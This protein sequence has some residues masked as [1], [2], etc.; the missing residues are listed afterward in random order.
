MMDSK[1]KPDVSQ[2]PPGINNQRLPKATFIE[3]RADEL[4]AAF[5]VRLEIE[6]RKLVEKG[7]EEGT[8]FIDQEIRHEALI[9]T[10]KAIGNNVAIIENDSQVMASMATFVSQRYN[11]LLDVR[12]P[13]SRMSRYLLEHWDDVKELFPEHEREE[14]KRRLELYDHT[15]QVLEE[16]Y[17][18][19]KIAKPKNA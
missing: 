19:G 15:I 3:E 13:P 14:R 16:K 7:I 18:Q 6:Y 17:D 1:H 5:K 8:G 2:A 9:K 11:E 4:V 12:L 10:F